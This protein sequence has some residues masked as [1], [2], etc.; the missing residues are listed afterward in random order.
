MTIPAKHRALS[1]GA[2]APGAGTPGI[3]G[4]LQR[5]VV[6]ARANTRRM[7]PPMVI[8]QGQAEALLNWEK[9]PKAGG[10]KR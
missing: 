2:L 7:Y 3:L 10:R 9:K 8:T 4:D 5:A 1:S 6:E